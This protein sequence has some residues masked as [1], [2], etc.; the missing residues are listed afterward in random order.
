[1]SLGGRGDTP[2]E[3]LAPQGPNSP[4]LPQ[5]AFNTKLHAISNFLYR[6]LEPAPA[7]AGKPVPLFDCNLA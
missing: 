2:G 6:R 5:K 7:Q 1:M 4:V 3:T